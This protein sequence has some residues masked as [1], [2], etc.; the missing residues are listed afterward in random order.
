M[1]VL[2]GAAGGTF[3]RNQ[4]VMGNWRGRG[5][6]YAGTVQR[7][8]SACCYSVRYSDGDTEN[9]VDPRNLRAARGGQ[10]R[11][12]N[13]ACTTG[14]SVQANWRGYGRYY[15]GRVTSCIGGMYSITYSDGD[16][17]SNVPANRLRSC[18]NCPNTRYR[19]NQQVFGNYRAEGYWYPGRIVGGG[20]GLGYTVRLADGDMMRATTTCNLKARAWSLGGGYMAGS[21]ARVRHRGG[22]R[23]YPA[24]VC[25]RGSRS[26]WKVC[27][28]DGDKEDNVAA[29]LIFTGARMNRC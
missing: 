17:E 27:Y 10:C 28:N 14:Y 22:N 26:G 25:G 24:M 9:C 7:V 1:R 2:R 20:H 4:Q 13:R 6:W 5:R 11:V 21:R 15:A 19:M 16:R 23:C 29:R 18:S 3:R 12:R 8:V